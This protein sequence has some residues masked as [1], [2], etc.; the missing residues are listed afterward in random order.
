MQFEQF[1]PDRT[2]LNLLRSASILRSSLLW[3]SCVSIILFLVGHIDTPTSMLLLVV[4]QAPIIYTIARLR[5]RIPHR[6]R[7]TSYSNAAVDFLA[8]TMSI[9]K[10]RVLIRPGRG[11]SPQVRGTARRPAIVLT[12]EGLATW[13]A[14][15]DLH[16][17]QLSHEM[18]HLWFRDLIRFNLVST[19]LLA[20]SCELAV[21]TIWSSMSG[22]RRL[23][24]G[25]GVGGLFL[26][27]RSLL[28][29][30]EF[31]ADF[32]A[33]QVL[34]SEARDILPENEVHRS[35]AARLLRSHPSPA[36][37]RAAF[38]DTDLLFADLRLT[39]AGLGASCVSIY[40]DMRSLT[41]HL[42]IF[43][44]RHLLISGTVIALAIL[45]GSLIGQMLTVGVL[46]PD[47]EISL[48]IQSFVTGMF[49]LWWIA[50]ESLTY[51]SLLLLLL[52]AV[53][54]G[55]ADRT[56]YRQNLIALLAVAAFAIHV[57]GYLLTITACT[58]IVILTYPIR[59]W[60]GPLLAAACVSLTTLPEVFNTFLYV[61]ILA[62]VAG[63][64]GKLLRFLAHIVLV[65]VAD[66]ENMGA[67]RHLACQSIGPI[68]M[69]ALLT[70]LLSKSAFTWLITTMSHS[71]V[72]LAVGILLA[73]LALRRRV[74]GGQVI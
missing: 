58:L 69:V 9:P 8:N 68:V 4:V 22:P 55:N 49:T 24:L 10:P 31:A 61:L 30:R 39:L 7:P 62:A 72:N 66:I 37:R 52:A 3:L 47:L 23:A 34:G 29:S 56:W 46:S 44:I 6:T 53:I 41:D 43:W 5:T 19:A 15:P 27:V 18:G 25:L 60:A 51:R 11:P 13:R 67:R 65:V 28:R 1:T 12:E 2:V 45:V 42:G 21:F 64:S 71:R 73:V 48:W 57:H 16:G 40:M 14:R 63:V 26:C 17:V 33:A 74:V 20:F 59:M 35:S 38:S 32:F 50:Y 70:C 36:E 54:V